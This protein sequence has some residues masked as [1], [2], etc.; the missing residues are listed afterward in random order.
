MKKVIFDLDGTLLT[1]T[2]EVQRQYFESSLDKE[3]YL[4]MRDNVKEYL[5][6]YEEKHLRYDIG[7]LKRFLSFVT[8]SEISEDFIKGW[9]EIG[10]F[11]D[12]NI[13]DGLVETLEY[14]KKKNIKLAVLTNWFRKPQVE[15]L[16]N[17]GIYKYFDDI[18]TGDMF[19]KPHK[20][21]YL[22][23][24]GNNRICDCIVV[25]DTL[26]KD[27]IVPKS[28]GIGAVL[29]DKDDNY[30]ETLVKVKRLDELKRRV[31]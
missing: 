7:D 18:Y 28:L 16:K 25:G 15:R 24:V 1:N 12:D 19:L 6:S 29:Y 9:I 3:T 21:A 2:Y 31:R 4:K 27:Y 11:I 30:H 17:T 14:F 10:A 8:C 22:N 13:E 26:E 20:E 5:D 23:A